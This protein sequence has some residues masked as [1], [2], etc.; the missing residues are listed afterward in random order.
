MLLAPDTL[1]PTQGFTDGQRN[2][3]SNDLADGQHPSRRTWLQQAAGLTALGL[4]SPW[5]RATTHP[6]QAVIL[7]YHRFADTVADNASSAG[8][9]LGG[10]AL[11]L[12]LTAPVLSLRLGFPD[13]GT[14]PDSRTERRSYDLVAQGF[15]PGNGRCR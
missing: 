9:V 4:I 5:A 10:T 3:H 7:C 15:G 12:A 11:L 2:G 13:E 6:N 8:F 14:L 1:A